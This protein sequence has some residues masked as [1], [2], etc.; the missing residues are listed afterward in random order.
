MSAG[1]AGGGEG[2]GW[3]VEE[4]EGGGG[5]GLTQ[6]LLTHSKQGLVCCQLLL[7]RRFMTRV[8]NCVRSRNAR[9]I[10]FY[11]D[12]LNWMDPGLVIL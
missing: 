9:L 2:G 8:I 10:F 11:Y 7:I 12:D 1:S 4:V 3:E 5:V 6:D